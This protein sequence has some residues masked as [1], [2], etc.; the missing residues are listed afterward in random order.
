MM[1]IM[2]V[3][4]NYW[5][6]SIMKKF[7]N[8]FLAAAIIAFSFYGCSKNDS[9]IVEPEGE[10]VEY[11]TVSF[12]AVSDNPGTKSVFGE[13]AD[14]AYPTIWTT[15]TKVKIDVNYSNAVEAP[16]VPSSDGKTASFNATMTAPADRAAYTFRA[17]SPSTCYS[18]TSAKIKI[19]AE[20]TPI[21]G[22]VDEAAHIMA[23]QSETYTTFPENVTLP[24]SHVVAYGKFT[25]KNFPDDVNINSIEI[26]AEQGVNLAG[27]FTLDY[28]TKAL[29]AQSDLSNVIVVNTSALTSRTFWIALN[30]VN[31]EGKTL[32]FNINTDAGKYVKTY[33]YGTGKGNFR[34]GHVRTL[35]LNMAGI[36]PIVPTYKLV[37]DYSELTEGSKVIIASASYDYAMNSNWNNYP[38][39]PTAITKSSDK[40]T[41]SNPGDDVLIFQLVKGQYDNSVRFEMING[42]HAGYYLGATI[43]DTYYTQGLQAFLPT[44]TYYSTGYT[45]YHISL[46]QGQLYLDD[47]FTH[48]NKFV[49]YENGSFTS[50]G[51]YAT[52]QF[53]AFY[54]LEGSGASGE[55]L[56]TPIPDIFF[57]SGGAYE[58]TGYFITVPATEGEYEVGYTI[59]DPNPA[60]L[61]Q[62]NSSQ[63][64]WATT[65][66]T[67]VAAVSSTMKIKVKANT[68]GSERVGVITLNYYWS[69]GNGGWVNYYYNQSLFVRQLAN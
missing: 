58:G 28:A 26:V 55:Q 48:Y 3:K 53:I 14:N 39:A 42:N 49:D 45:S 43:Q 4:V 44:E 61:M 51:G 5:R 25:L 56:I 37:T 9:P 62:L 59:K 35:T 63:P 12:S 68:T 52:D 41:I 2:M 18:G 46:T 29:T 17:I 24:F 19:P 33:T 23:A 60:G 47:S 38:G 10:N 66:F 21:D 34:T 32:T 6:M 50:T 64:G 11:F 54:K 16:V 1:T 31:M 69:D 8:L 13:L 20:Q 27:V 36:E 67:D 7:F 57:T 15:N 22:S 30:T 65:T 40:S